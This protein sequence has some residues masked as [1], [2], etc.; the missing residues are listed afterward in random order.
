MNTKFFNSVVLAVYGIVFW[1][2]VANINGKWEGAV[3]YNG[4]F[5]P[6]AFNFK[7]ESEKLTGTTETPLGIINIQE[8]K[9]EQDKI[10]FKVDLNGNTVVCAGRAFA[11]SINLKISFEGNEYLATLK[12][13]NEQ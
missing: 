2:N 6:M 3:N 4:N 7:T 5:V 9:V 11:D 1:I 8:G 12:R 13:T 10:N